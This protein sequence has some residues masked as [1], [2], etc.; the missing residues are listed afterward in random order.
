MDRSETPPQEILSKSSARLSFG[1]GH[2]GAGVLGPRSI[3]GGQTVEN[4]VADELRE[5]IL[6]GA[7]APGSRLPI[8][9]VAA[10]LSVS[11][12]PVRIALKQLA[13]EGLVDLTPHA[14]A[15]VGQLSVDELEE[16]LATRDGIEA[17]LAFTGAPALGDDALAE[18]GE[19]LASL[20][21]S[22]DVGDSHAYLGASWALRAPCYA[23]AGRPRLFEKASELFWR[24][25]RYHL[26][27]LSER[28]RLEWSLEL[29]VR[30][31]DACRDRD[32]VRA[33]EI[34]HQGLEWTLDYLVEALQAESG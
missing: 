16:L 34:T 23:G 18:M 15:T 7:V 2:P 1:S 11:V 26:L 24:S 13:G 29:F 22:V 27:N 4:L 5:S 19:A 9:D 32:G 6:N 14:G 21:C 8:R 31:F 28:D 30:F 10:W 12:T 17:W 20:R 25:R 3:K 33:R